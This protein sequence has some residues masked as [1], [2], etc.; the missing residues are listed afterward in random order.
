[1]KAYTGVAIRAF[2]NMLI[3]FYFTFDNR[4]KISSE[5]FSSYVY[6]LISYACTDIQ[7]DI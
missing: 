3:V 1:M 4:P 7:A 6:F 2:G 5:I